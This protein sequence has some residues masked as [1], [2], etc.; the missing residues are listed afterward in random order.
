LAATAHNTPSLESVLRIALLTF[1]LLA[2]IGVTIG[3][4]ARD[5]A[6]R[7]DDHAG[8]IRIKL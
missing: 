8:M 1:V 6:P 5:T 3:H 2:A 7:I 4:V